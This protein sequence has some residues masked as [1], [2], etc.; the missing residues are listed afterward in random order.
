MVKL[1]DELA[2]DASLLQGIKNVSLPGKTKLQSLSSSQHHRQPICP[3]VSSTFVDLE[4]E[5][6]HLHSHVFPVLNSMC[7]ERGSYF[8]PFDFRRTAV[9]NRS[10]ADLILKHALDHVTLSLPFFIC[11]IGSQYGMH[12]T[13]N[14]PPLL[15][16]SISSIAAVV[17]AMPMMDQN[18]LNACLSY[19]WVLEDDFHTCSM[20]E[21]EIILACFM[22]E[23]HFPKHCFF[24]IQESFHTIQTT[25]ETILES[26]SE[27]AQERLHDLKARIINKGLSVKFFS[28][29]E[30]LSEQVLRDWSNV[31]ISLLSSPPAHH[32]QGRKL[33]LLFFQN[34]F[35]S[36]AL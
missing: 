9:D 4:E 23:T 15:P 28:S 34:F 21:L 25:T 2:L 13:P 5:F 27:Y 32:I 33:E 31:V 24:Y 6:K 36:L 18:L 10:T 3:Y 16:S 22:P 26:E 14:S 29:K 11:I 1:K 8:L 20:L 35:C 7:V 30:E 12:R 19:P 17:P